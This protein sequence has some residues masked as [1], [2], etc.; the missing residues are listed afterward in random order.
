M[1]SYHERHERYEKQNHNNIEI[2]P[3]YRPGLVGR[4]LEMNMAYFG[5]KSAFGAVFEGWMAK[6]LGDFLHRIDGPR[7]EVWTAV[8]GSRI[9]G[10]IFIDGEDLGD[11]K[12]H[13][14][15]FIIGDEARGRGVGRRL[16]SKA[17]A[18]VDKHEFSETCLWTFEGLDPA[19]RLYES[20]GFELRRQEAGTQWGPEVNEQ[21]FVRPFRRHS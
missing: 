8:L 18:F 3:G 16:L 5:E 1:V 6:G 10:T 11:N 14:R 21:L 15:S 7:N 19:R 13:L 4:A 12:A 17:M 2:V 9:V 20:V